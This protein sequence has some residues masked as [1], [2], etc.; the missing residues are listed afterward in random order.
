MW[1]FR[2]RSPPPL[3]LPAYFHHGM[4]M[5]PAYSRR[6]DPYINGYFPP[7]E[8]LNGHEYRYRDRA[9]QLTPPSASIRYNR[10]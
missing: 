9:I 8:R 2:S 7:M 1:N 5:H 4:P 3:P 10:R 6:Y